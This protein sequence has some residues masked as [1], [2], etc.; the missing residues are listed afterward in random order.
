MLKKRYT[1]NIL[2]KI[3]IYKVPGLHKIHPKFLKEAA[4]AL[5]KPSRKL[6][7]LSIKC[8]TVPE[9]KGFRNKGYIQKSLKIPS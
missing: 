3:I 9:W 1:T 4:I 6:F 2:Q 7:E 5:S 8:E